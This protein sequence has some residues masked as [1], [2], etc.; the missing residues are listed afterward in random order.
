VAEYIVGPA[1]SYFQDAA[2]SMLLCRL[3]QGVAIR[4]EGKLEMGIAEVHIF[5]LRK[6]RIL[7]AAPVEPSH[8]DRRGPMF[9][10][11][12]MFSRGKKCTRAWSRH[13]IFNVKSH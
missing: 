12:E 1:G 10:V 8:N 11:R 7:K 3:S 6:R 4:K 5:L 9:G 2:V 13:C